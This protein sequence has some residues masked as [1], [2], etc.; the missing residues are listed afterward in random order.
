MGWGPVDW[1]GR[2]FPEEKLKKMDLFFL[3]FS[4]ERPL[5]RYL[6][7]SESVT[8]GLTDQLT[9]VGARDTCVSKNL[10]KHLILNDSFPYSTFS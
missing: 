10:K 3:F 8:Y 4:F 7:K 5:L 2:V 1:V 6:L 9:W